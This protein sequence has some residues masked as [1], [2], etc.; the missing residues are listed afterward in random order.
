MKA[1]DTSMI[2]SQ[3]SLIDKSF[4]KN[5]ESSRTNSINKAHTITVKDNAASLFE[6]E[7]ELPSANNKIYSK[8]HQ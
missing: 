2:G 3:L 5:H 7:I 1:Y 4:N 8:I 6:K